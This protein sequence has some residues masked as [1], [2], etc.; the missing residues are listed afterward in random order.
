MH[1]C[2]CCILLC[3][4]RQLMTTRGE[5]FVAVQYL[6]LYMVFG[7]NAVPLGALSSPRSASL[8]D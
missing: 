7:C 1:A 4:V 6:P 2:T 5:V 3:Q 8:C